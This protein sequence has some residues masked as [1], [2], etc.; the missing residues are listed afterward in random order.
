MGEHQEGIKSQTL[1]IISFFAHWK[2]FYHHGPPPSFFGGVSIVVH[3]GLW[4]VR[5]KFVGQGHCGLWDSWKETVSTS[6]SKV[7]G[8]F[9]LLSKT[10]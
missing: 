9:K 4:G 7:L 8:I 5:L 3:V 2:G 1:S 6:I 10:V